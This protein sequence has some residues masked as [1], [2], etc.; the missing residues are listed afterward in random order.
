M[1]AATV[2]VQGPARAQHPTVT[3]LILQLRPCPKEKNE[4]EERHNDKW[5]SS[6]ILYRNRFGD[7]NLGSIVGVEEKNEP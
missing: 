2:V 4:E 7:P 5:V 3:G 1:T 6:V